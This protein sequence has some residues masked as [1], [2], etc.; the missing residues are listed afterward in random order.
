MKEEA[1]EPGLKAYK[2]HIT[3]TMCGN[4]V[5]FMTKP[6][7]IYKSKN[8]RVLKNKNKSLLPVH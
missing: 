8:S 2:D 5:G 6:G 4:T 7:L 1:I 3:L